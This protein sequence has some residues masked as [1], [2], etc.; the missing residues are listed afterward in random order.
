MPQNE[1]KQEKNPT[2][3]LE[4]AYGSVSDARYLAEKA[5]A[6]SCIEKLHLGLSSQPTVQEVIDWMPVYDDAFEG[7]SSLISF[8]Y[9]AC[10]QDLTD[11]EAMT[12]FG[13]AQSLMVKLESAG[14]PLFKA[15]GQLDDTD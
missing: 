6:E 8:S 13:E 7:I 3:T 11:T 12:A 1:F 15:L 14:R 9:C 10:S 4:D 2:W 5:Y